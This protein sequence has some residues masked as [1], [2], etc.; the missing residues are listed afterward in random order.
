[1]YSK[2]EAKKIFNAYE[3]LNQIYSMLENT[4]CK[5]N[6]DEEK[7]RIEIELSGDF[8]GE[9][10]EPVEED[11][12]IIIDFILEEP[13]R[14]KKISELTIEEFQEIMDECLPKYTEEDINVT[15]QEVVENSGQVQDFSIDYDGKEVLATVVEPY[16]YSF[17]FRK[18]DINFFKNK[19]TYS[20]ESPKDYS[21]AF[22]LRDMFAEDIDLL[23]SVSGVIKD[24][25]LDN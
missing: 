19:I 22:K 8:I 4:E 11:G 23:D 2:F 21:L 1:M 20:I 3:S 24:Y 18:G 6:Y 25:L 15:E 7:D 9:R 17:I 5:T 12:F 13:S 16:R 10:Q 14:D